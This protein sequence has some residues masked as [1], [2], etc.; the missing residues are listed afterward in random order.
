[1]KV[2]MLATAAGPQG[3]FPAQTEAEIDEDLARVWIAQG[4]CLPVAVANVRPAPVHMAGVEHAIDAR[5][6][7]AERRTDWG[8]ALITDIDDIGPVLA[9]RLA[10]GGIETM[11]Q[12]LAADPVDVA[13]LA[14]VKPIRVEKWRQRAAAVVGS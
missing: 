8:D 2:R 13:L 10:D 11:A 1:M 6:V 7:T 5:A 14:S 9:Q 4:F 12:L 3:V